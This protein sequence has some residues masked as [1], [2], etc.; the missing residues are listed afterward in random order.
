MRPPTPHEI[1]TFER[2]C[3][4]VGADEI[5]DL[6]AAIQ[7][8]LRELNHAARRN[9]LL[10]TDLAE[11]LATKLDQ[12]LVLLE[13]FPPDHQ[14]FI[15]GAARYFVSSDDVLPDLQGPLGLD[16]DVAIFNLTV[17]RIERLD[18]E[19]SG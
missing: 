1:A 13:S 3:G 4:I 5:R 16:D 7:Q 2:L 17:R 15:V 10:A 14:R 18:L 11:E 8:H 9:E 6:R 19:I 12:L